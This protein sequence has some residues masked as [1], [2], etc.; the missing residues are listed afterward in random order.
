MLQARS[1]CDHQIVLRRK[2][3]AGHAPVHWRRSRF[4]RDEGVDFNGAG[5]ALISKAHQRMVGRDRQIDVGSR[6][7]AH[8][9]DGDRARPGMG[10]YP[11]ATESPA[12]L[13]RLSLG[14]RFNAP[15]GDG[16][17]LELI[18]RGK[19]KGGRPAGVIDFERDHA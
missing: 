2:R 11:C 16:Q 6:R 15:D 18:R 3:Y 5:R 17:S 1:H 14:Q 19:L 10:R 9:R 12:S 4:V 13:Y 7:R 8:A